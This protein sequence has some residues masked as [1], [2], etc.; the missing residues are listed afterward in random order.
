MVPTRWINDVRYYDVRPATIDY[1]IDV[2]AFFIARADIRSPSHGHQLSLIVSV[3][4]RDLSA[5]HLPLDEAIGRGQEVL[6]R[7]IAAH[8]SV[9]DSLDAHCVRVFD[10]V[11]ARLK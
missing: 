6:R 2:D 8:R 1:D 4:A 9:V 3:T 11:G 5:N 7:L 10:F